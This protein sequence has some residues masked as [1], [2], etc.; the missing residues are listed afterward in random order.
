MWPDVRAADH[1]RRN[2]SD[3]RRGNRQ[4]AHNKAV[5]RGSDS[6]GLLRLNQPRS[7]VT[8]SHITASVNSLQQT[9]PFQCVLFVRK[10]IL[11]HAIVIL[12]SWCCDVVARPVCYA[13]AQHLKRDRY[14]SSPN[15]FMK[16]CF[17]VF[18]FFFLIN[19]VIAVSVTFGLEQVWTCYVY[20]FMND[21]DAL[22][23]LFPV[24]CSVLMHF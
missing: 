9:R 8:T 10:F 22:A 15:L 3:L 13:L 7:F 19:T 16:L 23:F 1:D 12:L 6:D 5:G 18:M 11:F 2:S 20:Q 21:G 14:F 17:F 24:I 4:V